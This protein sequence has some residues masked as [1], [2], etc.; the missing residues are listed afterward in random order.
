[1]LVSLNY[2]LTGTKKNMITFEA[3]DRLYRNPK[4][5]TV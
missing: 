2:L 4:V 1:M 3:L 5:F